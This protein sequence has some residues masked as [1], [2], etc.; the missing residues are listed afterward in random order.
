[1]QGFFV[2]HEEYL[3]ELPAVSAMGK[4]VGTQQ[5]A[6]TLLKITIG[7]FWWKC[8]QTWTAKK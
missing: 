5:D 3:F 2:I 8:H 7:N 1:M 6:K 4:Y